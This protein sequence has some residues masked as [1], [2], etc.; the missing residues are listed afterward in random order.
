[1]SPDPYQVRQYGVDSSGRPV[2]MNVRMKAAFDESCKRARV[3]PTIVQGAYM[4][5][6]GGGADQS[7][8][9]HNAGGC[10]DTRT[11]DLTWRQQRR[12]IRAARTV[13]WGVWKRDQKHG[14]FDEHMHWVLL[15]DKDAT[16]DA[17]A[18]MTDYRNGGD[19][20]WPLTGNDDYHWRPSPIPTFNYA[21]WLENQM[22][23]VNDILSAK[24]NP[25]DKNSE[26]VRSAL[27]KGAAAF[28]AVQKLRDGS[29]RRDQAIR[30][31]LAELGNDAATK[32]Q[33]T[34]ARDQIIAVIGG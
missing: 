16:P 21:K 8:G 34:K 33:V 15:G 3:A 23:S 30:E 28:D 5:R 25:E 32:E 22:P 26:T 17:Q 2:L 11:W 29:A 9:T 31:A 19:G 6:A 20:L 10:I 24:L 18:Q 1:M 12:L 14:G 4:L 27:N 7:A 13:G